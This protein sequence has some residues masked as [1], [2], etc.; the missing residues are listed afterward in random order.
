MTGDIDPTDG[1]LVAVGGGY[2]QAVNLNTGAVTNL[3]TSNAPSALI[4]GNAPGFVWDSGANLFVGW[5]GGGTIYTLDPH[6]WQWTTYTSS[7]SALPTSP[8]ENGTFGRFEYDAADNVFMVVN[9][10]NQDVYIYKPNFGSSSST[11]ATTAFTNASLTSSISAD[12]TSLA[13]TDTGHLV[14]ND[15]TWTFSTST[16]TAGH[17]ILLNGSATNPAGYAASLMVDANGHMFA[18]TAAG[19]WYEWLNGGWQNVSSPNATVSAGSSGSLPGITLTGNNETIS[20]N[21]LSQA[22]AVVENFSTQLDTIDLHQVLSAIGYNAATS[23]DPTA[24]GTITFDASGTDS[25]TI[26]LHSG[27][28]AYAMVTLDHIAPSSVPHSDVIW[29]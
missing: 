15:G 10:I 26:N 2:L 8:N 13:G 28:H 20:F 22:G 27:G 25:T 11:F 12:G 5:N 29:H 6:T 9:D 18:D 14:T 7:D 19:Y 4:N 17:Q 23:G 21:S 24:N 3:S 1:L 16:N